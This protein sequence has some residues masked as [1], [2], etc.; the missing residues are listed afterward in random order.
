MTTNTT[1]I[2]NNTADITNLGD[3]VDN[4]Y[5]KGTKYFHANS[6]GTDSS[7]TGTDAIAIGM[8][9]VADVDRSIALGD[10]A[11][12]AAIV[13]TGRATIGGQSYTFAGAA[14]VG[15]LSIGDVG[16]ERTL[17]NVAAGRLSADSTDAVNGSQLFASNQAIDSITNNFDGLDG[18]AVKYD[19]NADGTVNHNKITLEGAP[20]QITNVQAGELSGTSTDAVN[21]SQLY[22]TNQQVASNT[23]NIA[24]NT[25]S[26]NGL[27]DDALLW[28]ATANG[29]KGAYSANHMGKG[30]SKITNVAEGALSASSTDAVNGSQLNA[31]NELVNNNINN[32]NGLMQD[33][34]LWDSKLGAFSASHGSVNV[35]K[36]TNVAAGELSKTST[37]AVNGSQLYATNENVT[38]LDG[39]VTN[40]E[41]TINNLVPTQVKYLKVNSTSA[42]SIA[43]GS[44]A[45]AIGPDSVASGDNSLAAGK[46]AASSGLGSIAMGNNADASGDGSVATGS[47]AKA[48]GENSTAIGNG[49]LSSAD[50][51]VALG[52]NSLADRANS[53]SIG[54]AGNERQITNVASGTEDTDAVNLAQL[55]EVSGDITNVSNS[56]TK[57]ANGT[58]GMFQVNNTN[59]LSKPVVTGDNALAGG[60][61]A[62]ASG[63]NSMAVGMQAKSS[64]TDSVA[65]GN[66][67]SATARNSV[68]LGTNS[69]ADRDNT[70]SI[71]SVGGERQIANVA[72]GT[73]GTDAVNVNQLNAGLDS[74]Y[75][76]TDNK[77]NSLKN[78]IDD[79]KDKMS[80]GIA[81]AMAMASLP[82]PY[83]PG[84]SMVSMGG[85]TFQNQSSVAL[86]VS[87]ISDNGKWVTKVA[88]TTNS[89]GDFGASVGVGYQW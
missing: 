19:L 22:D 48:S 54:S 68:A 66:A 86:G 38:N 41:D 85:G 21:G 74:S 47:N 84:A 55:K 53:V 71:G 42:G 60:A 69:V 58:D 15:T 26:I 5:N 39:R 46:G 34:L 49:A 35:N 82:Q 62:S 51:S 12:T 10:G 36:I 77:F 75:Q 30:S 80:A 81:G 8:G 56:I 76:Y 16:S 20:T 83:A 70:V 37:D 79:N 67:S 25:T 3:T 7:A 61:G 17:T 50:N 23:T 2:A 64:G 89:Q 11:K 63:G 87:T 13:G 1:N 28:D 4:I 73:K 14:P 33:A 59:N 6:T 78:M 44:E 24:N 9:A 52:A 88:G 29:G 40:I 32:I 27:K 31:T 57:I 18:R 72:A 45:I 65:L 43:T